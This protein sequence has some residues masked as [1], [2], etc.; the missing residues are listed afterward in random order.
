MTTLTYLVLSTALTWLLLIGASLAKTRGWTAAG[1]RVAFGNRENVQADATSVVGRLE[2]ASRNMAENLPLFT[3]VV[4]AAYLSGAR[5][6]T[7]VGAATFFWARVVYVPLYL[8]GI[9]YLRTAVWAVSVA[10]MAQ[11]GL[12]ALH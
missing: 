10:A 4:A 5:D 1:L 9:P 8:A 7:T 3:A 2:R 12:T 11:I 6:E